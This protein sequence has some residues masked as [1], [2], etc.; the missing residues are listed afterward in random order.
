MEKALIAFLVWPI[1]LAAIP[2]KTMLF[3]GQIHVWPFLLAACA[4]TSLVNWRLGLVLAIAAAGSQIIERSLE[5]PMFYQF[6]FY[7]VLGFVV[8]AKVDIIGG[9]AAALISMVYLLSAF[10]FE[11]RAAMILTEV[12]FVAGL[13]LGALD[14]PSGGYLR[15]VDSGTT[16]RRAVAW[17]DVSLH[18]LGDLVS[19]RSRAS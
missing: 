3:D 1:A 13:S 9:A 16:A 10:G 2:A 12:I 14:G 19:G 8:F 17:A 18:R 4:L 7:A 15:P 5:P 6:A 11:W